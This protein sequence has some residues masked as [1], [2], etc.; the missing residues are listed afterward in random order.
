MRLQ[1]ACGDA[2]GGLAGESDESDKLGTFPA[3]ADSGAGEAPLAGEGSHSG[4]YAVVRPQL[5]GAGSVSTAGP[6][7]QPIRRRSPSPPPLS[8]RAPPEPAPPSE[9]KPEGLLENARA[10]IAGCIQSPALR[11]CITHVIAFMFGFFLGRRLT[12]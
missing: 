10:F 8:P 6:T 2:G 12:R 7:G 11:N 4:R 1:S 5:Q 3:A 9:L